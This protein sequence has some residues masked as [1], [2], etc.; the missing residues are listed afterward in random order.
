VPLLAGLAL[1]LGATVVL[2]RGQGVST[3]AAGGAR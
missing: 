3:L 2:A 1:N